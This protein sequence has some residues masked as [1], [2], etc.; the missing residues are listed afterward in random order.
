[1]EAASF[2]PL[3]GN[4]LSIRHLISLVSFNLQISTS[5][6]THTWLLILIKRLSQSLTRASMTDSIIPSINLNLLIKTHSKWSFD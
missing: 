5:R 2:N 4:S 3:I 1:M 6:N